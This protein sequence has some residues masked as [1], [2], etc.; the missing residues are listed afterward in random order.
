MPRR[1]AMVRDMH[2]FLAVAL[3]SGCVSVAPYKRSE[4]PTSDVIAKSITA[5]FAEAKLTGTPI[6]SR[7]YEADLGARGDWLMC[8]RGSKSPKAD[9]Y[10]MYFTGNAPVL[11]QR[12]VVIDRCYGQTFEPYAQQPK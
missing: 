3:L 8:L 9:T 11:S 1:G 2:A 7:L 4:L 6:V 10:S 12:S 5:T